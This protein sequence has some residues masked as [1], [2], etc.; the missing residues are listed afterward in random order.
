MNPFWTAFGLLILSEIADK[1]M[2]LILG[3]ALRYKA[4]GQVFLGAFTAHSLMDLIAV[5]FGSV[6]STAFLNLS[7]L[8]GT[9][10][11]ALGFWQ[12]WKLYLH[13]GKPHK[14]PV[15]KAASPFVTSFLL[16]TLSEFGDKSQLISGLLGTGGQLPLTALGVVLGVGIAIGA[17]VFVTSRFAEHVP[18]KAVKTIAALVFIGFG[19]WT[20]TQAL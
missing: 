2:L 7:P 19:I 14:T 9:L 10:F 20:L 18:R 5:F 13:K 12:L 4:R 17:N 1:T 6:A 16:I 8:V 11:I 15:T 3:L